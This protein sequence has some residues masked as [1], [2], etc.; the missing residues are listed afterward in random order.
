MEYEN[1]Y[2]QQI[3]KSKYECL[4]FD[5]DD[6][7]YPLSSG[8]SPECTKNIIEY[9]VN[10]LDIEA[11][12]VPEMCAQLYKDYGTT[13]AGLR[14]LGYNFDHD[15]YHSFVHGRLP[16]EYLKPDPIL[17][18]LLHSLPIRKVIFSNA[19]E[20]HVAEVLHRL[21]LEDCFDD[22]ICF[23]SL[24]PPNQKN[25]ADDTSNCCV[26]E[27]GDLLPTS[28]IICKPFENSFQQAFKMANINPHKTI[29]FDDSIRNIQTAKVTG[30]DTVLV[31]SSE[32]KKGVDYALESIH[33]IREA[34]PEL[35]ESVMKSKD[36]CD[37]Q[38]IAIETSVKA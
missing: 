11:S 28:P 31:G 38:K 10:K 14:A 1:G 32:R 27:T 37:S 19:N 6:T 5:V 36:V 34:L 2:Q 33:N 15:D 8:L 13:M 30:L 21:G 16:Y 35:W 4:L 7:L 24:N 18:S 20:A 9:M 23:E 26:T 12:K 29:F 3:P 22:V 25:S 17:R